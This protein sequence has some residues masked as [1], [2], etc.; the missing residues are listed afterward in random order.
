MPDGDKDR[1]GHVESAVRLKTSFPPS[2]R[3]G[4]KVLIL[5]SMPGEE[6]LRR[7]EY[8]AFPRNAFWQ[9]MGD[10]FGFSRD[11]PYAERLANLNRNRIA[12]WD[13]LAFCNREGSL[14][15]KITDPVPNDIVGLVRQYPTI[16]HIFCNGTASFQFL[17][18]WNGAVFK[19]PV[20]IRRLPS[21]SPAA[22]LYSYAQKQ[23]AYSVVKTIVG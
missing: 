23:E 6:S 2:I 18:R 5:G 16:T 9:I 14:D 15:Q 7:Q 21:T 1:N 19:L 11:L 12:L 22:A 4:A 8:Y 17:K 20:T 10:L 13:T 3:T